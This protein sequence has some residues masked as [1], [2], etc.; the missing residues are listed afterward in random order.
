MEQT[1]R[2]DPPPQSTAYFI[3]LF[4]A[5][6]KTSFICVLTEPRCRRKMDGEDARDLIR[7]GKAQFWIPINVEPRR[8]PSQELAE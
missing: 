5:S 4:Q 3:R 7:V 1:H 2:L 8:L 6:T